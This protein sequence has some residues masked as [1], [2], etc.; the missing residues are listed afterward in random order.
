MQDIGETP[1]GAETES[2]A[3]AIKT[4]TKAYPFWM[5]ESF[6]RMVY[7]LIGAVAI[8]LVIRK[9]QF[10]T[11]GICCG[12][13]DGYYHIRWSR[14]LWESMRAKH[15][16]PRFEWLPLTT[17]NPQ[18]YVDHHLLFHILQ[19]PF[20][21][22]GDLRLGAKIAATLFASLAL[23][24]CYWLVIRYRIRYPIVWLV[25]LLASSAPFLY[26]LN[27]AKAPPVSIIF[28]VI[29]I[30]LLFERKYVWLLPLTFLYVWTYSLFITL[31]GATLIWAAVV[32]WSER[33]LEWRAVLWMMIGTAA[34][35]IINPYFPKNVRLFIEHFLMKAKAGD[36]AVSVG[37]EWYP[38]DS[39]YFLG[40]CLIA[41]AAMLV[42]Y[43]AF[44]WADKKRSERSLF[45]LIFSTILMVASFRYRRFVEY[46]P[47]FAVLFAA[48]SIKPIL[49]GVRT[50]LSRLP[51]D[52]MDELKPFLDTGEREDERAERR[53]YE[54]WKLGVA[55]GVTV[56][57]LGILYI[58]VQGIK[59]LGVKGIANEIAEEAPPDRYKGGMEW[60]RANVPEGETVFNT[61][62]DDFP[63]MFFYDTTHRYVSGLDPTYLLD[64]NADLSKLYEDITLG[65]NNDP[66]PIIRD[67]FGARY[68]FTDNEEIHDAFYNAAMDSGWFE[69]VYEDEDCTVLHIRDQKGQPPPAEENQDENNNSQNEGD[70][71]DDNSPD[72]EDNA[73]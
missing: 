6:A 29:G 16:P 64:S 33:K 48:F 22:F 9:I 12:D 20:T 52:V 66:G 7:L 15:F 11:Q 44:D 49:E 70:E 26:R 23:L 34:G 65:K 68:I 30:Y 27:M 28:M 31:C 71:P 5:T 59:W 73:P 1:L 63:K 45:L 17:L 60:I 37:S 42:G 21:W 43:I 41:F 4:G 13:F 47:P 53:R 24:S 50:H 40:S 25:A 54:Y 51:S 35:F 72:D 61:D 10:S 36:F 14:L 55:A 18:N 2:G 57:L 3:K 38:Y 8:G 46:W 69:K 56:F 67:R 32:W 39:W 62:W 19:I 58:N